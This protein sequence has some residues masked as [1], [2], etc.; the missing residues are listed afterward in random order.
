MPQHIIERSRYEFIASM[1]LGKHNLMDLYSVDAQTF[2]GTDRAKNGVIIIQNNQIFITPPL[3][4][5]MP[6]VISAVHPVILKINGQTLTEP[7]PITSADDLTWEICE[8]PQYQITVSDDKLKV[9]FTLYR[10]ERYAWNLVNSPAS[11]NVTVRAEMNRDSLLSVL[12]IAQIMSGFEKRSI[13][14]SLNIPA[15]YE[16][17][18]NPTYLPVCIAEGKAPVPGTNARLELLFQKKIDNAFKGT[19]PSD[20]ES[21]HYEFLTVEE[22]E[23][24]AQKLPPQEGL[25]GFTVY[26]GVLPPP[27]PRDLT[28]LTGHY[29]VLLPGGQIA[30]RCKGRPRIT[31]YGTF[32][33]TIDFPQ[34]YRVPQ[35]DAVEPATIRFAGDIIAA[36]PLNKNTVIEA[37]GN[38][39]IYGDV[40]HSR[41]SATGS[42]FISGKAV[43]SELYAGAFGAAHHRLC[44]FSELL[45]QEISSLRE[46]A[47][48]LAETVESTMQTVKYGLVIML[49]LESKYDHLPL[50][51][52]DMRE[53]LSDLSADYPQDTKIVRH[54]MDIFLKPGHFTDLIT[55]AGI[56]SFL[57]LL[58][59]LIEGISLMQEEQVRIDISGALNSIIKSGGDIHIHGEG[60]GR[61][62]LCSCGDIYFAK[63]GSMCSDS[64]MEAEGT[65]TAQNVSG[66]S[67][68]GSLLVAG[69]QITASTIHN[70]SI[71]IDG[72]SLEIANPDGGVIFTAKSLKQKCK[73]SGAV[74]VE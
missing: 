12:S 17:L 50:L 7:T 66:E 62:T 43:D 56:G 14:S 72:Y 60:I 24:F 1:L 25:P 23:V 49:L 69:Q 51:I 8:K 34:T 22:G 31:G 65:I 52:N 18:N 45:I 10:A 68:P 73:E 59:N 48:N 61:S 3:P 47:K 30:A 46:A 35:N 5:G 32:V 33:K 74:P 6:A 38:V 58:K 9:Y 44:S 36:H 4:G 54:M 70:A 29:A 67:L 71:T 37:L 20:D 55:D 41:I 28:L 39:Y 15:L 11:A 64:A 40:H 19:C 53:L 63:D 27:P 26:G 2:G 21:S 13:V 16:E 42:I 57:S